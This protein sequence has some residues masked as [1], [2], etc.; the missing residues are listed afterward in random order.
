MEEVD[1]KN[2]MSRRGEMA[3]KWKKKVG[4]KS[5]RVCS[6]MSRHANLASCYCSCLPFTGAIRCMCVY[7]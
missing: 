1:G 7:P 6:T 5:R 3:E 4:E 2:T